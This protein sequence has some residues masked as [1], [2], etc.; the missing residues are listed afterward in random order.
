MNRHVTRTILVVS[1]LLA[2]LIAGFFYTWSFTI[3]QSLNLVEPSVASK[4][5]VAIN[6]NIRSAWFAIIFFGAPVAILVSCLVVFSTSKKGKVWT[7]LALAFAVA[8][9]VVT[10][11]QHLPLNDQLAAGM[12]WRDY[13]SDWVAWNH[14]RMVTSL[15]AFACMLI[16]LLRHGR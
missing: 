7:A 6:A 14:V 3:M 15:I 9:L 10:F 1:T 5:M 13:M 11:S 4:A 12:P 2:G 8:T 16:A